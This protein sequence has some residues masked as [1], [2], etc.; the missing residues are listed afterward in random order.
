MKHPGNRIIEIEEA[1]EEVNEANGRSRSRSARVSLNT[2]STPT[3]AFLTIV[4]ATSDMARSFCISDEDF[5]RLR[6]EGAFSP[7]S[8]PIELHGGSID[9]ATGG[10]KRQEAALV[11]RVLR[12]VTARPS[13]TITFG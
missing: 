6:A 12:A 2:R 11:D 3:K 1:L 5:G 7:A 10:A 13:Q 8:F 9:E 4:V